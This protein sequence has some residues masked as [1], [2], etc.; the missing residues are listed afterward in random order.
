MNDILKKAYR[1][2]KV[3]T[4]FSTIDAKQ[5]YKIGQNLILKQNSRKVKT[6]NNNI[7]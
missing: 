5:K 1:N 3:V 4:F 7:N 6:I 2:K